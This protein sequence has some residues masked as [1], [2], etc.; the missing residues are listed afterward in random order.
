MAGPALEY[1]YRYRR[2]SELLTSRAGP[3]LALATFRGLGEHP[4]FFEGRVARPRLTADLLRALM[5]VVRARFHIPAATLAKIVAAADPV[6][7]CNSDRLRFEAFSG[8]ASTYARVDF[9]PEAVETETFGRGTTNV[10]FHAPMIAALAKVRDRDRLSLAVGAKSVELKTNDEAVVEK[11]VALPVRWLKGFVEVQ[12]YQPRLVPVHELAGVE[13]LRFLRGLPRMK[14]GKHAIHVVPAGRGLRLSQQ[15]A[16]EGVKVGGLERL[17]VLERLAPHA[18]SLRVYGDEDSGTS[19]WELDLGVARFHL[20][21]SPDVWRGFSGEGQV[22]S[23]LA[24][25]KWVA[26]LPKVQKALAWQAT[27]DEEG[28]SRQTKLTPPQIRLALA[29]LAARGLVGYDLATGAYFHRELPFDLSLVDQLQP[30][31]V[32]AKK[33]LAA[34]GVKPL[35]PTRSTSEGQPTPTRSVSE[36]VPSSD[37]ELEFLVAGSGVEHRVRLSAAG[38]RCTCPWYSKYQGQ[39][40]PCKHVLAVQMFADNESP[41]E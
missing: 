27:I 30:R 20:V 9:L 1:A 37:T 12:A 3:L 26:A 35:T 33:L 8:C 7:T 11:K 32:A 41:T 4:Y 38:S 39:R 21:L 10:D 24:D 34:G 36:G 40:G 13:A 14:T 18:K 28:L 31:L 22:L 19:G 16:R 6:V 2:P 29:A 5:D 15:P 17:R 23:K 25:K